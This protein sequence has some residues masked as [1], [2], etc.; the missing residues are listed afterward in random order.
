MSYPIPD[1]YERWAHTIAHDGRVTRRGRPSITG[2]GAAPGSSWRDRAA[3]AAVLGLP[4]MIDGTRDTAHIDE[5]TSHYYDVEPLV[6]T[7]NVSWHAIAYGSDAQDMIE[8]T[9]L[10]WHD[11]RG[12]WAAA[13]A[14][15]EIM[16]HEFPGARDGSAPL[17]TG[18][19]RRVSRWP[20]R[21]RL[22]RVWVRESE[23]GD[24][25]EIASPWI[26]SSRIWIGHRLIARGETVRETRERLARRSAIIARSRTD[27][28][29][30]VASVSD[31]DELR[32][33]IDSLAVGDAVVIDW[34]GKIEPTRETSTRVRVSRTDVTR[35]TATVGT[36]ATRSRIGYNKTHPVRTPERL[37]RLIMRAIL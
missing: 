13:R 15:G 22:R 6:G 30:A 31:G 28:R 36:G 35:Y 32:A 2:A 8:D 16:A 24:A 34:S 18:S 33:V 14:R 21:T 11:Y 12:P 10:V 7:D 37:A 3:V 29:D 9:A 1:T 17:D 26:D 25:R 27:R 5:I 19:R 23:R 20:M 4:V